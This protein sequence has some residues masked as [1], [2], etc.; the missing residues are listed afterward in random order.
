RRKSA[1]EAI[2]NVGEVVREL[3]ERQKDAEGDDSSS[4]QLEDTEEEWAESY[5]PWMR[6]SLELAKA[7][8]DYDNDT[9]ESETM[10]TE[11]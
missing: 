6:N 10:L 3:D 5:A 7:E 4:Y 11:D 8:E 1:A 9:K 2:A